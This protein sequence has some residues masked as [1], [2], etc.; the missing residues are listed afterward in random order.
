MMIYFHYKLSYNKCVFDIRGKS[1]DGMALRN[2]KDLFQT[3]TTPTTSK[4]C[5]VPFVNNLKSSSSVSSI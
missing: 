1:T 4:I 2:N 5:T 3:T